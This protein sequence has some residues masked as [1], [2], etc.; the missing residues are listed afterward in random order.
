MTEETPETP[1]PKK[2]TR[3]AAPKAPAKPTLPWKPAG[4]VGAPLLLEAG[5]EVMCARLTYTPSGEEHWLFR[6]MVVTEHAMM[7]DIQTGSTHP[8]HAVTGYCALDEL[9]P[10]EADLRKAL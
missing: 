5:T 1:A 10:N 6:P 7:R 4:L 9:I 2:R 3:K 8:W